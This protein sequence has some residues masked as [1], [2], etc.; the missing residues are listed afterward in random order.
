MLLGR[1]VACELEVLGSSVVLITYSVDAGGSESVLGL[2]VVVVIV[3]FV[4]LK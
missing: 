2:E 3:I 4:E 1:R